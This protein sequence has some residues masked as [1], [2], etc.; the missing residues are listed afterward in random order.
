ML[1]K[2]SYAFFR[3][4]NQIRENVLSIIPAYSSSLL[5]LYV[6]QFS[7]MKIS[8]SNSAPSPLIESAVACPFS[9]S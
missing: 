2:A 6:D 4:Y 9:L 8:L 7:T 3:R 5:Y 1:I